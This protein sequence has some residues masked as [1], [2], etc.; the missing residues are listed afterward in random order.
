MREPA[1]EKPFKTEAD[2]CAHFIGNH[3]YPLDTHSYLC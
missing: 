3:A 1:K 2:L